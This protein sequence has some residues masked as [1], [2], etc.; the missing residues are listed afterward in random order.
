MTQPLNL[1]LALISYSL[2]DPAKVG[3][4]RPPAWGSAYVGS[5]AFTQ[6][7]EC[8]LELASD[9]PRSSQLLLVTACCSSPHASQLLMS[10][11]WVQREGWLHVV[12]TN[13]NVW[14][15]WSLCYLRKDS[16]H[17]TAFRFVDSNMDGFYSAISMNIHVHLQPK[18]QS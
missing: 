7:L 12:T 6:L 11:A 2:R 3:S 4:L 13:T 17:S 15:V 8:D 5:P 16:C 10:Q 18:E 14:R 9:P 1:A